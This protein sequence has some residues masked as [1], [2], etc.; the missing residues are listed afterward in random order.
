MPQTILTERGLAQRQRGHLSGVGCVQR[1]LLDVVRLDERKSSCPGSTVM[2]SNRT[3]SS[4]LQTPY[5][6]RLRVVTF[7]D[8]QRPAALSRRAPTTR[9]V[10]Q[11]VARLR[12]EPHKRSAVLTG[13]SAGRGRTLHARELCG[14]IPDPRLTQ[15]D[16]DSMSVLK[17]VTVGRWCA[18]QSRG[19]SR[20]PVPSTRR[21]AGRRCG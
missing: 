12:W 6:A 17:A 4:A 11:L 16:P 7:A 5:A 18:R 10:A 3:R 13:G 9:D 15:R 1:R 2:R 14:Q 21:A 8:E 20:P 19:E